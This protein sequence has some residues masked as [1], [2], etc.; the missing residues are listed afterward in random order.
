MGALVAL[1][2]P[3]AH[4][5]PAAEPVSATWEDI[6][7]LVEQHPR[8]SAGRAQ[9]D[10][11]RGAVDAACSVPNPVLEG[12][13]GEGFARNGGP[14]RAEWGL[15]LTVPLGWVAGRGYR[16]DAAEAGVDAARAESEGLR[17][18]VLVQL[19]TLYWSLVYEQARV[20]SLEALVAQ[21]SALAQTV[22]RRVEKGEA[23]PVEATR[24]E[25]EREKVAGELDAARTALGARQA[26]LALW[27]SGTPSTTVVAVAD[28]DALPNVVE[29]DAALERVRRNHP[30]LALARARTRAVQAE[31]GVEER[32]R[33]P[34]FALTGYT[35]D[36]LDARAFGVGVALDLPLWNWNRGR[37]AGAEASLAAALRQAEATRLELEASVVDAQAACQASVETATRV[38]DGVLPRSETAAATLEKT[39][40]LGEASLLEVI[41][42]R[43]TLLDA[44]R[45]YLGSLAQAQIDC[46]RLGALVGEEST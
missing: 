1:V 17:R 27:V 40:Q 8:L 38:R 9:V 12:T 14:S 32:A 11:A 22:A 41:D 10:A 6:V 35:S 33:V 4:A 34:S 30:A 19:R 3:L 31:V 36:Q 15:A 46:S 5:A 26:E 28:L 29:R 42:A 24:V 20:A 37:I 18:D 16:I 25:I 21:T 39:Y 7:R 45:S 2:V 44:R 43:R 13:I 23:R